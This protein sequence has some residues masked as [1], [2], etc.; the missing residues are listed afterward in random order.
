MDN[1]RLDLRFAFR[2]LARRP[3]FTTIAVI[4]LALGIGANTAI[5]SVVHGVLLRPL[6]YLEPDRLVMVWE[7]DLEDEASPAA[8]HAAGSMSEPGIDD[9]RELD[10]V[11]A[12]EGFNLSTP[13][14]N[15]AGAPELMRAAWVTGGLLD[16][17][18][19]RP[20]LGRDL[21]DEDAL[22][23]DSAMRA[24]VIGHDL[25]QTEFGG[26]SDVVGTTIELDERSHEVVG[27]APTG[28]RFPIGGSF[29][30]EGV[31]LWRANRREPV[32]SS[33]RWRGLY[34]YRSIARL[35]AGV[36][37]ERASAELEAHAST[38]RE[39]YPRTNHDKTLRFEPLRDFMVGDVRRPLWIVL[40]AVGVVLLI[41]CANVANLL[42]VRAS[43]RRGEVAVRAA[44]GASHGRLVTQV[45]V[46]GFVL[47]LG[48]ALVG[49]A[50]AVGGIGL[51]KRLGPDAIPRIDEITLDATVLAFSLAMTFLIALLFGLSPALRIARTSV[52]DHL[53][54]GEPRQGWSRDALL[55]VEIAMSL[56]LLVGAGLL[57]RSLVK[58]YEVDLGFD[59]R[60]VVRFEVSLPSARY[61]SLATVTSFY[62]TLEERIAALPDVEAVGSADY[63]PLTSAYATRDLR[64]DGQPAPGPGEEVVVWPRPVTPGYFDAMRLPLL[65]GRAIEPTDREGSLPIGVVN[66]TFVREALGGEDPIGKRISAGSPMLTVV[67]VVGDVR[68]SL[69]AEPEPAVYVPLAQSAA[70]SFFVH[71]RGR[72]G[73]S[74]LLAAVREQVHALDPSLPLRNPETVTEAIRRDAA[75]TRFLL[76]LIA[77]FA[78]LALALAIVGLYGV[79]SYLVSRRTREIGIRLAL[80]ASRMTITRL[81]LRHALLPAALGV[82]GGLLAS[83]AVSGVMRNLLFEVEPI[84]PL[85]LSGVSML[86]FAVVT[87]ASMV[88]A[89]RAMGVNPVEVLRSE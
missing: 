55:T 86:L 58:L 29:G 72:P 68:R 43:A 16:M 81:V 75:P 38:L 5:F 85:V 27:V 67:G 61:D 45:L 6:P 10:A 44:L 82:A 14:M 69:K 3:G 34:G 65:R 11:S 74:N 28:F 20:A 47:A 71:V 32:N 56:V 48:G 53:R 73:T 66:E 83:I 39:E 77:L 15:R 21:T 64:I 78:G 62:R 18:G 63:P 4:T 84:D 46:E 22:V 42:L 35:A 37:R 52:I 33:G 17:F 50:L 2:S 36:S 41:A 19:L 57:T 79:V 51:L 9:V 23:G 30:P 7:P 1:L 59:G 12:I 88:P 26:R 49:L 8:W 80:G 54:S 13:T 40:G 76:L 31:Q 25:W 24:I 70:L 89:R 87:L 60:E